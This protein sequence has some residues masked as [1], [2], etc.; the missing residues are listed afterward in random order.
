ML[1]HRSILHDLE[2]YAE[3]DRLMT[4]WFL[5]DG[6][7]DSDVTDPD[8]IF[9]GLG[10]WYAALGS[11]CQNGILNCQQDMFQTAPR[12]RRARHLHGVRT[13]DVR[14]NP[15]LRRQRPPDT[16]RPST[17][18][19]NRLVRYMWAC[20]ER[21]RLTDPFIIA[22]CTTLGAWSNRFCQRRT[23][24]TPRRLPSC[25]RGCTELLSR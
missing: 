17:Y 4:E 9:F 21:K 23:A 13:T 16:H 6:K 10:R 19:M 8:E 2:R 24:N 11:K 20:C 25:G 7:L 18:G 1:R 15:D 5:K 3:P 12:R 14:Y 22:T